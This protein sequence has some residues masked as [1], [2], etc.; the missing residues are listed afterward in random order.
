MASSIRIWEYPGY[1]TKDAMR[2]YVSFTAGYTGTFKS[3]F[4]L[5][6]VNG[7]LVVSSFGN[8]Y[9]MVAG[10][11]HEHDNFY[12]TFTG[13]DPGTT[14][15]IVAS[16]YDAD[17]NTRLNISEPK[18][19]FTTTLPSSGISSITI[20]AY[21]GYPTKDAM[22]IYVSFKVGYAG[23]FKTYYEIYKSSGGRVSAQYGDSYSLSA[24]GSVG[25]N[26]MYKTF[27]GLTPGTS[28]YMVVS[29]WDASTNTRLNITEPTLYFTTLSARPNDWSWRT[30]VS[31]GAAMNYSGSGANIV[32]KPLTAAEWLD[33][34]DRIKEFYTYLGKTVDSTYWYRAV[35]GVTSG[36]PMTTTQANGARY[37]I[38]ALNPSTAVPNAVSQGDP[39]TAAFINGLKNSL[40]SID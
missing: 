18:L 13:L 5:Y 24:G 21:P 22:R 20:K 10:E 7:E 12:K 36:S 37:L 26:G 19:Y 8:T 34:A 29:L 17:T 4:E 31:K 14:Y 30:N 35:N 25:D 15:Y 40:N 23:T 38:N 16:L 11:T 28:Y 39:I 9:S 27:T 6:T 2:V 3:Y 1:P 33:F 32:V